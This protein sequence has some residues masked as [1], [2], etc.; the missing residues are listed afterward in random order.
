MID[1]YYIK[2]IFKED[3]EVLWEMVC[4]ANLLQSYEYGVAK[5]VAEKWKA[6]RFLIQ[7]KDGKPLALVQ[8]LLKTLPLIGGIARI[9]RGPLLIGEY[10]EVEEIGY[11]LTS[12]KLILSEARRRK[13]WAV[14]VAPELPDVTEVRNA[15]FSLGLKPVNRPSWGSGLINLQNTEEDI[16]MG[17]D[18]KWRNCLR[19]G[20]RLGVATNL[21]GFSNNE[22]EWL[23]RTYKAFQSNKGFSGLSEKLLKNLLVQRGR[24]WH[25][26]IL[27]AFENDDKLDE[28][29]G[30]IVAIKHG[31]TATYLIG[32][33]NEMGRKLQANYVLLWKAI[34]DSKDRGCKW[35]DIGGLSETTPKGV[36]E[37]KK[38]L[39]AI[40]YRLVG[41][42]RW[43]YRPWLTN[44]KYRL[45]KRV[46]EN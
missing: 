44:A 18:G 8:V 2:E 35:F 4:R 14:L 43:C 25:F 30:A 27:F 6:K 36:A 10:N 33:T 5:E 15:L 34:L 26:N 31:D 38:G 37:F 42:W 20:I 9:N 7:E 39:K 12:L 40:P 16:L 11:K 3:Y 28:P 32:I 45:S 23:N 1:R 19:K 21:S 46:I 13:W 24:S 17:L 22:I 29:I 41:E